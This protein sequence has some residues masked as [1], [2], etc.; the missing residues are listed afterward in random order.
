MKV[1]IV[2]CDN[3]DAWYADLIGEV[4]E[5]DDF[6]SRSYVLSEDRAAGM[7]APWRHILKKDAEIQ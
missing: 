3:Q 6:N 2:K 7:F 5:V 4:F 1:K